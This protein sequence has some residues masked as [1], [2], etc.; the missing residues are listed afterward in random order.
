MEGIIDIKQCEEMHEEAKKAV[1]TTQKVQHEFY[2]KLCDD[3]AELLGPFRAYNNLARL[4]GA[5]ITELSTT[6]TPEHFNQVKAKITVA[7]AVSKLIDDRLHQR[8]QHTIDVKARLED[9]KKHTL[10]LQPTV[11]PNIAASPMQDLNINSVATALSSIL[12]QEAT[13]YVSAAKIKSKLTQPAYELLKRKFIQKAEVDDD[14]VPTKL[15]VERTREIP[16]MMQ[17]KTWYL[18][19][20]HN[21]EN[22]GGDTNKTLH[23]HLTFDVVKILF[24]Y[25]TTD[26]SPS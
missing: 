5:M 14:L 25:A 10:N 20:V 1:L 13:E 9:L 18:K 7:E 8:V 24:Y 4:K 21:E 2:H 17:M 12:G 26:S 11:T 23:Q 6:L 19:F 22:N 3:N 15:L 16:L